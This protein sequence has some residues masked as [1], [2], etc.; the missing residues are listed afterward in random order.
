MEGVGA[1]KQSLARV[2]R[3]HVVGAGSAG[4][5]YQLLILAARNHELIVGLRGCTDGR[6]FVKTQ[7]FPAIRGKSR[8]DHFTKEFIFDKNESLQ[9]LIITYLFTE[10]S[11]G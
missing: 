2:A 4:A 1:R 6:S 3:L 11:G 10:K 9:S 5:R 8:P 7:W